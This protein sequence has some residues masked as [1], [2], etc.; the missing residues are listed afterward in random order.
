[1]ARLVDYL[2]PPGTGALRKWGVLPPKPVVAP[3]PP[4][5]PAPPAPTMVEA[6]S[7]Q[8]VADARTRALDQSGTGGTVRNTGGAA[9]MVIGTAT[10]PQGTAGS[11]VRNRG[12]ARG[13]GMQLVDTTRALKML[14]GQ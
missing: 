3:P 8:A 5:P 13:R 14:T 11:A 4:P 1:M 12:G 2:T 9:G 7:S 10:G 6:A